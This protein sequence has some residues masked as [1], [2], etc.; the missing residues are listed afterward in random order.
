MGSEAVTIENITFFEWH[1]SLNP[2]DYVEADFYFETALKPELAAVAIAKEQSA[3]TLNFQKEELKGDF[4]PFT[5]RIKFLEVIGETNEEMLRIYSLNT[6][7]YPKGARKEKGYWRVQA[8]IAFPIINFGKSLSNMWNAVGG[9]VFRLGFLN[10]AKMT[11]I[12]FPDTYLKNFTGPGYGIKGIRN[13]LNVYHR[14]L[15]CRSC[16]PAVGL[17]TEIM[18][19]ISEKVFRGGFDIIKDDELTCDTPQSPFEERVAAMMKMKKK[20]EKETGRPR[21]Y[22]ANI[23]DDYSKSLELA[24]IAAGY[25]VDAVLVSAELQGM[26]IASEIMKFS[27]MLVFDHCSWEDIQHRHPR[28]GL[29]PAVRLKLLRISGAD[30]LIMPGDYA[31]DGMSKDSADRCVASCQ[32]PRTHIQPTLPVICGGKTA[33]KLQYYHDLIGNADFMIIAATAVDNHPDG[34]EA[35]AKAFLDAWQDVKTG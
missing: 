6:G 17:T 20:I 28:F 35:G 13:T 33:E 27:D 4:W 7:V 30:F 11:D 18:V 8:T 5:A 12:R 15:F 24:E 34:L 26:A 3:C 23:I 31:T 19:N 2:S 10:A 16:R 32:K 25:G 21:I 22:V 1:G 29:D 9:E 14:P